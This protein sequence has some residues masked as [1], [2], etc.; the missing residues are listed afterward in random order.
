[1]GMVADLMSGGHDPFQEGTV[2]RNGRVLTDNENRSP[3]R[4]RPGQIE[5][6]GDRRRPEGG[7]RN[8]FRPALRPLVGPKIVGVKGK[9][10]G[11]FFH[12]SW[13]Y[14]NPS[15]DNNGEFVFAQSPWMMTGEMRFGD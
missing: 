10:G 11:G 15:L 1:V 14:C 4:Q 3:N 13:S 9:R 8:P 12:D 2:G 7:M 6:T 5:K